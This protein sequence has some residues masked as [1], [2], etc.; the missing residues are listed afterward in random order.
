MKEPQRRARRQERKG[1]ERFGGVVNAASGNH[2]SLDFLNGLHQ[3]DVRTDEES[4]EFKTT[5]AASYSLKLAD[6]RA[7]GRHALLDDRRMLFGIEFCPPGTMHGARYVVLEE[8]DY[9]EMRNGH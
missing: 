2:G 5:Q 3:N 4:I 8:S 6:L 7:A 1:A 9:L